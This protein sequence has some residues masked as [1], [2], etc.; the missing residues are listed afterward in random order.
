[1]SKIWYKAKELLELGGRK[2]IREEDYSWL[3]WLVK[4]RRPFYLTKEEMKRCNEMWAEWKK[5]P[6]AE[7]LDI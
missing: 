5:V 1:M 3:Y 6:D 2:S 4:D 7:W